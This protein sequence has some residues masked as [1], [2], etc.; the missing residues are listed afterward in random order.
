[1]R[2]LSMLVI[3]FILVPSIALAEERLTPRPVDPVAAEI[4]VRAQARSAV[5]RSLVTTLE[6]SNVIVHIES[7]R[8]LPLGIGGTTRFVTSSGGYRYVRIS[9]SADLPPRERSSVLGHELQHACE[10][11]ESRADDVASLRQLFTRIG[12]QDGEFYETAAAQRIERDIREELRV[13]P[14]RSAIPGK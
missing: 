13:L 12:H 9:I 4:F 6:S 7:S 3:A 2:Y 14:A 5:V 8:A 11:A 10:I 1:M